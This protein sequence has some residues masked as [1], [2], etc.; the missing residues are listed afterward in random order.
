M[1]GTALARHFPH[2][3]VGPL[4]C[5]ATPFACVRSFLTT[6]GLGLR[7]AF[8]TLGANVIAAPWAACAGQR[9][10]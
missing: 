1:T 7:L 8:G 6:F 4:P 2:L 10:R 5:A 3:F 9:A